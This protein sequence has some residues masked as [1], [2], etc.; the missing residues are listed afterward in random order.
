MGELRLLG[1]V[2]VRTH[3]DS[4]LTGEP[5][6]LAVLAALAVD[7]GRVVPVATLI[8]RVW[9]EDPPRQAAKTLGT[10]ITRIRRMLE[11]AFSD[12]SVTVVNHSGGYRLTTRSDQVDLFRFRDLVVQARALSCTPQTR[13][14]LLRQSVV[15]HRGN[16]LTGV[17]GAW[18]TSTREHLTGELLTAR[19][20][21]AEAE[22][23]VGNATA[24]LAPLTTLVDTNP[25]VESL[26]VALVRA[27]VVAGRP[28]EALERC[29]LHQQRLAD[30]YG[31]D[32]SPQL[33]AL[34]ETVLRGDRQ[35]VAAAPATR[36]EVSGA[37]P[38]TEPEPAG[39]GAGSPSSGGSRSVIPMA[40]GSVPGKGH[41]WGRRRVMVTVALGT[42]LAITL[43]AAT[44]FRPSDRTADTSVTA[45]PSFTATENFSGTALAPQQWAANQ[46]QRENGS[47]WSPGMVRVNGGELQING[48][49]R[50]PSGR[51][52]VAGAVCW[53][54]ERGVVRTYGVWEIRAKFDVGPGYAPVM[55]LYPDV[56]E[57]TAGWGFL[58]LARLD[59]G[60]RRVMYPVVRGVGAGPVDGAAMT[61]DFTTWNTYSIEWRADFVTIS[62]NGL[63]ILDTRTFSEPVTIPTVPMFLY[64]QMEPGPEGAIPAPNHQTPSQV[65]A[66]VDWARYAS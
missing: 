12:P 26:V 45:A 66:H 11:Q 18:A 47:S 13:V 33:M 52:N 35:P 48:M 65:T 15:L 20:E 4:V 19:A 22:V 53:C 17:N 42:A 14:A 21:W 60:E 3:D 30:G 57:E 16:P 44:M 10:Y 38:V 31:T 46:T 50:N 6:C 1:P 5:R 28:T 62:L 39:A 58:T 34:Y 49:G 36:Y 29:R 51:G 40:V 27:L 55:G 32:P 24:V 59:D 37:W 25:L 8:D 9:G 54:L 43:G 63:V 7:A 56:P 64:V 41:R 61:G 2:E 23:A